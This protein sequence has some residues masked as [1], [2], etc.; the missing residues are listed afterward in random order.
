MMQPNSLKEIVGAKRFRSCQ[1]SPGAE[2]YS[3]ASQRGASR[4]G[5]LVLLV[6]FICLS[7]VGYKVGPVYIDKIQFESELDEIVRQAG[8]FDWANGKTVEA[9][10]SAA[11][12]N[13]FDVSRETVKVSKSDRNV[14]GRLTVDVTF[15]R[16]VEFPGYVHTFTFRTELSTFIGHL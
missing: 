13:H 7:F 10:I 11:R 6:V 4:F 8:A 3:K 15:S 5:C 9:V 14:A 1:G 16:T 2:G 12:E